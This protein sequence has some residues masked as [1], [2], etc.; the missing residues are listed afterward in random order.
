[1]YFFKVDKKD[2][3]SP[4]SIINLIGLYSTNDSYV[5]ILSS[6]LFWN[7]DKNSATFATGTTNINNDFLYE[8]EGTDVR[9]VF[10]EQRKFITL[11][12]S[13]KLIRELYLGLLYLGTQTN[14]RFDKGSQ[15]END[16]TREFFERN[17]IQDNFVSSIGLNISYDTRDYVYYPTKGLMFSIRPKLN[18]EWL[19]SDNDY[20]DTDYSMNYFTSFASNKVLGISLS[21]GFA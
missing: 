16:F 11:E 12:Y 3:I 7:Q 1:M 21:G 8:F 4:P 19:G 13:R 17:N 20:I 14:Y 10:T 9:L 6:R 18:S 2:S 5:M 15:E